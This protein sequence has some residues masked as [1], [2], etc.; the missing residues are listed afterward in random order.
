[1]NVQ[2]TLGT[3]PRV[4][5]QANDLNDILVL[6]TDACFDCA[7]ACR[8]CADACLGEERLDQLRNCI[9][10]NLDCADVCFATGDLAMRRVSREGD[11]VIR[12]A[13]FDESVMKLMFETCTVACRRCEDECMRYAEHHKHCRRC[14]E[15]CRSCAQACR[16]AARAVIVH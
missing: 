3:R 11:L 16:D 14:A 4:H 5:E 8:A 10:M 12:G 9:H 15:I 7:L 2:P 1:M 13:G 6:A